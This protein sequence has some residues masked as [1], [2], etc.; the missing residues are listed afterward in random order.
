MRRRKRTRCCAQA[1][2]SSYICSVNIFDADGHDQFD[3]QLARIAID[4]FGRGAI[5]DLQ[6]GPASTG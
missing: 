6:V 2:V 5:S 1:I 3:G 4:N